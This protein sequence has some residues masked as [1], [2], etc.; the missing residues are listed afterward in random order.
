MIVTPGVRGIDQ[1]D[2]EITLEPPMLEAIVQQQHFA[3][4]FLHGRHGQGY[5]ISALQ[6]RH[7]G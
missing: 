5:P 2:V 6:V 3:L 7:V 1:D 4:Q